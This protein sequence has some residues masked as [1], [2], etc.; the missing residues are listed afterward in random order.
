[1]T[2]TGDSAGE[3]GASRP[4]RFSSWS[5]RSSTWPA[6][7]V[8][9]LVSMASSTRRPHVGDEFEQ[10]LQGEDGGVR[11][12]PGSVF[13]VGRLVAV[14]PGAEVQCGEFGEL[15]GGDG[16]AAVGRPVHAAVVDTDE[17]AVGGQPYIALEGVRTVLD[18]LLVRGQRVLGGL[19]GGSAV[20]DDLDRVLSC[21]GH[22]VMVPPSPGECD[23]RYVPVHSFW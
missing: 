19:F 3:T 9:C 11:Q 2:R 22:G 23:V 7:R 12:A 8:G 18:R 10:S 17:M 16:S 1:M 13:P 5:S 4:K 15:Q 21:E 6:Q 14:L 20:G